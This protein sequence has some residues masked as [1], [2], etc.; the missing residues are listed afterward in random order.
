MV[1]MKIHYKLQKSGACHGLMHSEQI[2][3]VDCSNCL[4][5][6]VSKQ[7]IHGTNAARKAK[8]QLK[9]INPKAYANYF[10]KG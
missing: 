5:N 9:Q 7:V 10:P 4:R 2:H 6:I 8:A 3:L 1:E